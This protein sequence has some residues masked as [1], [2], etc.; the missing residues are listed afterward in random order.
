MN[1]PSDAAN[2]LLAVFAGKVRELPGDPSQRTA[3]RKERVVGPVR[4]L[5]A[6]LEGDE[7]A[8]LDVHGGDDRAVL[9]YAA[10]NYAA[11]RAEAD[12]LDLPLGSFAENLTLEGPDERTVC[13]GDRVRLGSVLLEVSL[14]RTP[15]GTITLATGVAGL[16]EREKQSGR[17]GW[18]CRVLEEGEL[19][20]GDDGVLLARPHPTWS[21][22]R[23]EVVMD[24]MRAFSPDAIEDARALAALPELAA[25]WRVK[26]VERAAEAERLRLTSR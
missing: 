22:A 12:P 8:A 3:Y 5:R 4:V 16:F 1:N 17:S 21:V 18:L 20:E 7:Q 26:L 25:R 11:F 2:R 23:A 6:G 24:R 10:G 15:C 9:A 14:P 13:I 19:R